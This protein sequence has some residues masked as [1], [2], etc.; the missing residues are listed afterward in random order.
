MYFH[1]IYISSQFYST[2]IAAFHTGE[3]N[4]TTAN[5]SVFGLRAPIYHKA[6]FTASLGKESSG[7]ENE[8]V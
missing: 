8:L 6:L 1:S 2:W 3:M 5:Q 7:K 4:V